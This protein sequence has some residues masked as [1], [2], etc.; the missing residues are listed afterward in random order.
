MLLRLLKLGFALLL[1]AAVTLAVLVTRGL[2]RLSPDDELLAHTDDPATDYEKA[3]ARFAELQ[4]QEKEI[5]AFN[6]VCYS[7]LLT[8]GRKTERAIILQH[9]Q[10]PC[11]ICRTRTAVF[12]ARIQR[13]SSAHAWKWAYG[14]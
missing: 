1:G 6:P 13:L 2:V 10:L 14:P 4:A 5:A 8:H 7:Q 11:A 9:D 3:L 12:R